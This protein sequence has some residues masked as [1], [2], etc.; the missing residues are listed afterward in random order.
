MRRVSAGAGGEH[1]ELSYDRSPPETAWCSPSSGAPGHACRAATPKRHGGTA[2]TWIRA[3]RAV[4]LLPGDLS[5]SASSSP[6]S[7]M[8][9]VLVHGDRLRGAGLDLSRSALDLL[10]PGRWGAVIVLTVQAADQLERQPRALLS[11]EAEELGQQIGRHAMVILPLFETGPTRREGEWLVRLFGCTPGR[12]QPPT[13]WSD[14][15]SGDQAFS[16]ERGRA[17]WCSV[18]YA[19]RRIRNRGQTAFPSGSRRSP[20]HR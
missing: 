15:S 14:H 20:R 9:S 19:S 17:G 1:A 18:L 7:D 8:R 11:R 12:C 5:P 10:I 3:R 6:R 16:G 4:R 2:A 13:D